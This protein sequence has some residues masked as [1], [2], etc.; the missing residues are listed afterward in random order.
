[1]IHTI[2]WH[3][4]LD[5]NFDRLRSNTRFRIQ[6]ADGH[7]YLDVLERPAKVD[8]IAFG[9]MHTSKRVGN[10]GEFYAV[11]VENIVLQHPV[12]LNP[13]LHTDGKSFGP[14][15]YTYLGDESAKRLMGD[16]I[17]A[18]HEQEA[19][20]MNIYAQYFGGQEVPLLPEEIEEKEAESLYEGAKRQISVNAYERNPEARRKCIAHY[21]ATCVICT[22]NFAEQYGEVGEGFIHVHHLRELSDIDERYKVDPIQDLKPVC[23]NCHA[24]I[25]RRKPAHT[26]DEVREFLRR[27]AKR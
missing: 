2:I 19:E 18:N 6:R 13:G 8:G 21:G 15:G 3:G 12:R 14:N 10:D 26:I 11:K 4:R 20:L 1:M 16:V 25:H 17:A 24:I 22:L 7:G 9:Y 23:P 5:L 27:A